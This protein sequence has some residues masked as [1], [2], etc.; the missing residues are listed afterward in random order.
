MAPRYVEHFRELAPDYTAVLCDI[1][2]V[3]HNGVRRRPDACET[4][5]RFRQGGGRVAL[6]TNAPRPASS[7]VDQLER[8]GVAQNAYDVIV[9]SGDMTRSMLAERQGRRMFHLGPERD[10]PVLA[11]FEFEEVD[12]AAA[13][14]VLLT[15]LFDDET[16]GPDDYADMF[17]EF[18]AR[19]VPMIC[20]NPDVV[21]ERGDHLV[22]CAGALAVAY[23]QIGGTV[24]SAGKPHAPIYEACLAAIGAK[25]KAGAIGIGDSVRTDLAGAVG[26]GID[27]L[28]VN[29]GIHAGETEGGGLD[30]FFREANL[31]PT[32]VTGKLA[33]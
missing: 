22:Y 1:W 11:G 26:F 13:E 30:D 2:G 7:V 4:L 33:W 31:W 6:V 8:L 29:D 9:T 20:A 28:F 16:E 5:Q 3:V 10:R 32:A 17:A 15:G 14:F 18:H 21:V 19:K 23:E 27:C 12:A 25:R 24:F